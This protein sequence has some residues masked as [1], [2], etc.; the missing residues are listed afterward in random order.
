MAEDKQEKPKKEVAKPQER[1]EAAAVK[2]RTPWP[3]ITVG[4]FIT[5][6]MAA[7]ALVGWVWMSRALDHVAS[8]PGTSVFGS[9]DRDRG[10]RS[11]DRDDGR[12]FGGMRGFSST[13]ASG[14]VTKID[15]DT[16]TIA[17]QGEQV[18]V[19]RTDDT[20]ISG[21]ET[22]LAVNDSVIV[23]GE[24]DDDDTMTATHIIVQNDGFM[25]RGLREASQTPDV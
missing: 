13:I 24:T 4:V 18:T 8:R 19:K 23:M 16:I 9:Q 3:L 2:S 6:V 14:V 15:G 20:I 7:I 17:G 12:G 22:S 10:G 25:R 11:F 5:V 21:D 1:S